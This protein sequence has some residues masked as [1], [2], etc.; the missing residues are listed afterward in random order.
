VLK[1]EAESEQ[2]AASERMLLRGRARADRAWLQAERLGATLRRQGFIGPGCTS[3]S[4]C[5]SVPGVGRPPRP[6]H[7]GTSSSV[8]ATTA[9]RGPS[10]PIASWSSHAHRLS[11]GRSPRPSCCPVE[12]AAP[13]PGAAGGTC[14]GARGCRLHARRSRCWRSTT[15]RSERWVPRC[16]RGSRPCEG[17]PESPLQPNHHGR[18]DKAL[19]WLAATARRWAWRGWTGLPERLGR[20]S[21]ADIDRLLT[22]LVSLARAL[23][24]RGLGLIDVTRLCIAAV[25]GLRRLGRRP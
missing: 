21:A 13:R 1:F 25:E 17:Q 18:R 9:R 7:S 24:A 5:C 15:Q 6:G 10:R 4:G 8:L 22:C 16:G 20:L 23:G 19:E 12:C 3:W 2:G 11:H 14:A